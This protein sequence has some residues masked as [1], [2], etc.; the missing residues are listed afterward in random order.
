M[1]AVMIAALMSSLTSIFNSASTIF[2]MDL[3]KG[4]RSR[5]SEWELMIVGRSVTKIY[6]LYILYKGLAAAL[7]LH[8]ETLKGETFFY[9]GKKTY[10]TVYIFY[11]LK[12][13]SLGKSHFLY[14]LDI[15]KQYSTKIY[16]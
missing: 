14:I 10:I 2:T 16:I 7:M 1:M 12:A 13:K 4:F 15:Y 9:F 11:V 5:A 8:T 3:W 6:L